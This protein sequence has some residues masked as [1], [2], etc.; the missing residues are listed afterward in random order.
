MRHDIE[1]TSVPP[2]AVEA[3]TPPGTIT[4]KPETDIVPANR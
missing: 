4:P 3:G 2:P 1:E